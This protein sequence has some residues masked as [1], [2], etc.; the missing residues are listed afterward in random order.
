[1]QVSTQR[2]VQHLWLPLLMVFVLCAG[3]SNPVCWVENQQ[4][5]IELVSEYVPDSPEGDKLAT[6]FMEDLAA[7]EFLSFSSAPPERLSSVTAGDAYPS[8][9]LHGPPALHYPV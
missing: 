7:N 3:F 1:M 8:S 4:Q 9:I 2:T 5:V 6:G